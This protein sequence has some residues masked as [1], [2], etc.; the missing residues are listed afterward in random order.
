VAERG[1]QRGRLAGAGRTDHQNHSVGL[2]DHIDQFVVIALQK[3][4][5]FERHRFAFGEKAHDDVFHAALGGNGR[6]A[7]FQLL[8]GVAAEFD[9]AVLRQP[10]DG[11][12]QIGHDLDAGNQGGPVA[13]G[14]RLVKR[15]VPVDAEADFHVFPADVRFDVNVGG[16]ARISV[17]D[18]LVD[19]LH[20]HAVGFRDDVGAVL[21]AVSDILVIEFAQKLRE[22]MLAVR[23][24]EKQVDVF[25]DVLGQRDVVFHLFG[26]EQVFDG[27][28]FQNV[29]GIVHDDLHEAV[30]GSQGNPQLAGQVILL[31][32][33]DEI[34]GNHRLVVVV[35][36]TAAVEF[37]E[38][39]PDVVLR[40]A[41]LA[42][43]IMLDG[44]LLLARFRPGGVHFLFFD[45]A[46][47]DEEIKPRPAAPG[48][49]A[50][51]VKGHAEHF[52][53]FHRQADI[54]FRK[55]GLPVSFVENLNNAQKLL[56]M[57]NRRGQHLFRTEAGFFVP[58]GIKG[59]LEIDGLELRL[60]VSVGDIDD[61]VRVGDIAGDALIADRNADFL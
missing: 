16:P 24:T 23:G 17:V 47:G 44:F 3:P 10:F 55:L 37:L 27:V 46:P 30:H 19:Q 2:G 8:A 4:H 25:Q 52:R 53:D 29:V 49:A 34:A 51:V 61:I 50:L 33:F 28:P 36:E 20:D 58:A 32:I 35:D 56:F 22:G 60:I 5:F 21:V 11:D 7:Q 31:Q 6:H 41:V 57:K 26:F 9:F 45:Q 18:D 12:V 59:E 38:R 39:M 15:A 48:E 42:H 54:V 40:D 1:V 43:E 13:I 14:N